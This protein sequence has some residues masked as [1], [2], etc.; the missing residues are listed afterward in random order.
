MSNQERILVIDDEEVVR[1]IFHRLLKSEGFQAD[2]VSSGEEAL[3]LARDRE[4]DAV[5]L[6]VMMNGIGGLGTLQELRKMDS[7]IPVIMVTAYASLE[8]AIECMKHGAFDYITK[9][10]K[11]D[12]VLLAINKAIHQR[13]LLQENKNLKSQLKGIYGFENIVGHSEQM[14]KVFDLVSQVAPSRSTILITGESGTGKELIAKA[15]HFHSPRSG[16][17]FVVVN[18]G[19]LPPDLLESNLF[20]HM[21][22]SFTGAIAT[23]K[24]LFEVADGGS[25]FFDE[26]GNINLDTQAKLLRVIQEKEFMR[27]GGVETIHVD[28]RI[29]AATN[30]DLYTATREGKFRE[31]LYY[32]LNVISIH[33]PPLRERMEDIPLL[34]DYFV[35]KYCKENEKPQLHMTPEALNAMMEYS[36]PGNVREL[37]NVI[38]RAVVLCRGDSIT[39]ELLPETISRKT[40]PFM[41]S[42]E[43]LPF[44]EKVDQ[45][46]K[47]LILDALEK[48]DGIQKEAAR[49]LRIKPT[50]LNEMIK[51]YRIKTPA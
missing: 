37:E 25:I 3:K 27:V 32:R 2:L 46:R 30:S 1:E 8:N 34:A 41:I 50:T 7:D 39:V 11:N 5:V 24:G 4:Y 29:I 44:K 22:G 18:S 47:L 48:A 17:P 20:G 36:W 35:Q 28:V 38:E 13:S 51:R 31:D 9:P 6:D 19:S 26:I 14:R 33:L 21:K 10:F 49:L 40:R 45:Y 43:N 12:V 16:R 42:E 23:K 15:I